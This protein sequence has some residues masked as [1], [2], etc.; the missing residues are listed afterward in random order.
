MKMT[1][2]AWALLI[3]TPLFSESLEPLS[4][5]TLNHSSLRF[6]G[7]SGI[8]VLDKGAEFYAVSDK[9]TIWRGDIERDDKGVIKAISDIDFR[10][11]Q[12]SKGEEVSGQNIDAEGLDSDLNGALYISFESNARVSRF[13]DWESPAELIPKADGFIDFGFNSGPEALTIGPNEAIWLSPERSGELARPFP[14]FEFAK[15]TWNTEIQIPRKEPY[16]LVGMDFDAKVNRLYILERDYA[17]PVF[18]TRIRSFAVDDRKLT[19]EQVLL[20]SRRGQYGDL[21][22]IS[23]WVLPDGTRVMSLIEDNNFSAFFRTQIIEFK[24]LGD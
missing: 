6:G 1:Q 24:I 19:D 9:G 4:Q 2:L 10:Y 17:F 12:T 7:L 16:L 15:G 21:E 13:A 23:V 20:S 3:A 18:S 22:G 11:I 14:I 5:I 8:E